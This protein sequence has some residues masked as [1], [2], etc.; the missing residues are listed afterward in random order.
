MHGIAQVVELDV[1][2]KYGIIAPRAGVND[3]TAPEVHDHE[4]LLLWPYAQFA[5]ADADVA[6]QWLPDFADHCRVR[7]V[8]D[9]HNQHA[10]VW[11]RTIGPRTARIA[12]PAGTRSVGA[13]SDVDVMV[14]D[15]QSGV[16]PTVEERVVT[17]KLEVRRGAGCATSWPDTHISV[18]DPRCGDHQGEQHKR[19]NNQTTCHD[20]PPICD[21]T[22]V[23]TYVK[24]RA[25]DMLPSRL[26]SISSGRGERSYSP[27]TSSL[28]QS[29]D[30]PIDANILSVAYPGRAIGGFPVKKREEKMHCGYVLLTS[31]KS[32][33]RS[34]CSCSSTSI[35][36]ERELFRACLRLLFQRSILRE[37]M[38]DET[39]TWALSRLDH[40]LID[41]ATHPRE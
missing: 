9:V 25:E 12:D 18:C 7:G 40:P 33:P 31:V 29:I 30:V 17:N 2:R 1:E 39:E 14:K 3:G 36:E 27:N 6:F 19:K 26:Q 5:G 38:I 20:S 11:M 37:E 24:T 8:G 10:W 22:Q 35:E 34:F 21:S 28:T 16:H 13:V 4:Q 23:F 41:T 15:G 32:G